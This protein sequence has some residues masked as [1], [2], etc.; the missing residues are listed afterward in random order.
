[1][2]FPVEPLIVNKRSDV[3]R[4]SRINQK[5]NKDK[6]II[7]EK[8]CG[9]LF[10]QGDDNSRNEPLLSTKKEGTSAKGVTSQILI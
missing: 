3:W 1:M 8:A 5:K 9:V 6:S 10:D 4:G 2:F 7:C